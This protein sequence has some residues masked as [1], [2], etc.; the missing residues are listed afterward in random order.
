MVLGL[1]PRAKNVIPKGLPLKISKQ[2]T[3][4]AIPALVFSK[5]HVPEKS[6]RKKATTP[7]VALG[8]ALSY[9]LFINCSAAAQAKWRIFSPLRCCLSNSFRKKAFDG[10]AP[11]AAACLKNRSCRSSGNVR[12]GGGMYDPEENS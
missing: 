8:N 1:L 11:N 9:F 4:G 12:S 3:Y 10:E 7:V 6:R 5:Y 2:R